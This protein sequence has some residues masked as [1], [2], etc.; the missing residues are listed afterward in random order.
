MIKRLVIAAA[1]PLALTTAALAETPANSE[2]CLKAALEIAQSAEQKQLS[3]E[4]LDK[5]EEMLSRMEAHCDAAQFK[6]AAAVAKDI[7]GLISKQ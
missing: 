2:D 4:Q 3:N 6:E 1:L 5:V 7:D